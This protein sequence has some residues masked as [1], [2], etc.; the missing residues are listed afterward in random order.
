LSFLLEYVPVTVHSNG[1]RA[2]AAA[3]CDFLVRLFATC[4]ELPSVYI[5]SDVPPPI[6]GAALSLFFQESRDS[7]RDVSLRRLV[8]SEDQMA[9]CCAALANNRGLVN[10]DLSTQ[11]I[12]NDNWIIL[13]DSLKAHPTL[14]SLVLNYTR[15]TLRPGGDRIVLMDDQKTYRT[16]I[17]ADMVQR[18]ALLHTIT[19]SEEERDQQIYT[20]E[21]LPHLETNLY[22]PRVLAVKK[23]KERPF[24][25]K[26][27]GR[28]LYCVK[29]NPNLVWMFL[30]EN[31]DAFARTEEEERTS[32][33]VPVEVAAA[34][35]AL[36][37]G[38]RKR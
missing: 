9:A 29:S 1:A 24:R 6:S 22:R 28:A 21:I 10:L 25:E 34:P 38:K 35:A 16:R 33:E 3:T 14:T 2:A 15:P 31:V 36:V 30:S 7:L 26:V 19:L 5:S 32:I 37:G 12:S 11:S 27:L 13:C 20:D 18:N 23:T 17:I 4:S 8:L